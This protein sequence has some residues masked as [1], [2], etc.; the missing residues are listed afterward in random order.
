[1]VR[2]VL[3]NVMNFVGASSRRSEAGKDHSDDAFLDLNGIP[4]FE[5]RFIRATYKSAA[6]R[7]LHFSIVAHFS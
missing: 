7:F 2:F 5:L 6:C 3:N 1:M 4:D